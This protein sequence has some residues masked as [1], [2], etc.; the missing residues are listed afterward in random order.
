MQAS[1]VKWGH[2]LLFT[3]THRNKQNPNTNTTCG[4]FNL[5]IRPIDKASC[6]L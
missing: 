4:N 3:N 6:L 1:P 5:E 2:I